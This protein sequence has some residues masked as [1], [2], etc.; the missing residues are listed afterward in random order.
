MGSVDETKSSELSPKLTKLL[1]VDEDGDCPADEGS[2]RR[3]IWPNLVARLDRKLSAGE[4]N[5]DEYALCLANLSQ[6]DS[7][8]D[9]PEHAPVP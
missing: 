1:E 5:L 4:I 8:R 6:R 7:Y 3:P 2:A 9:I